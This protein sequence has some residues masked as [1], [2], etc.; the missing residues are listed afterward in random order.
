[1]KRKMLLSGGT[2]VRRCEDDAEVKALAIRLGVY[3]QITAGLRKMGHAKRPASAALCRD[4]NT[5]HAIVLL[6]GWADPKDNGWVAMSASPASR[7]SAAFLERF[8]RT[9]ISGNANTRFEEAQ[10]PW[11]N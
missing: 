1:M 7:D 6:S 3:S 9:A 5:L 8:A 2:V 4:G 10:R 11:P